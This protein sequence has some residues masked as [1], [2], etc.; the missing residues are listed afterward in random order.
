M[1]LIFELVG[2][3]ANRGRGAA[4]A[5]PPPAVIIAESHPKTNQPILRHRLSFCATCPA[6]LQRQGQKRIARLKIV[7]KRPAQGKAAAPLP[8]PFAKMTNDVRQRTGKPAFFASSRCA[9]FSH[10]SRSISL[11]PC[12]SR[13]RPGKNGIA[14]RSPLSCP[15]NFRQNHLPI[16]RQPAMTKNRKMPPQMAHH[17]LNSLPFLAQAPAGSFLTGIKRGNQTSG[18]RKNGRSPLEERPTFI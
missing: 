10:T 18:A 1:P 14:H 17:S 16:L 5:T 4:A 11:T 2:D 7:R 8:G 6:T 13:K 12:E 9:S 15:R 3:E